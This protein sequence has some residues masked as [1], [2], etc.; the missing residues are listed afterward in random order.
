MTASAKKA[1]ADFEK[2]SQSFA[3]TFGEGSLHPADT[4]SPYEVIST[5]SLAI[6]A[7]SGV[8]GYVQGRLVEV[9]GNESI[10]KS[11]LCLLGIAE[12]QK[13]YP[14]RRTAWIDVEHVFDRNWAQQHGVDTGTLLV[15]E[16][17][18][19][20]DVADAMKDILR[21]G[22]FSMVVLDS[23]GA[24]IP[25]AEKEK[26]ADKAVMAQQAKIVTRMVKIAA[27]EAW[28]ANTVVI[29]IN[30]VRANLAYGAD[31]TTGG[32]FALKHCTTMKL[33][34][35]RTGEKPFTIREGDADLE[36]GR[37]IAVKFERNKVAPAYRVAKIVM[38]NQDSKW[39]PVGLDLVDEAVTLGIENTII[40]QGGAWYTLP[41]GDR[42]QGRAQVVEK[43]RANPEMIDTIRQRVLAIARG[44]VVEHD[45]QA[46]FEA[47]ESEGDDE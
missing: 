46:D 20:E 31:T 3:K 15:Y 22:F 42:V 30:Q 10:G 18:S 23:I 5:G 29:M 27:V 47:A 33:K 26:D 25:E 6:D 40:E 12:A 39:G 2:F 7:R 36:V 32:G 9:W 19:A 34:L 41:S 13:K 44:E 17:Q 1:A 16:P 43:V 21:S 45:P 8:G 37:E 11:T 24:M 14:T 35:S 28:L 38:F 4:N